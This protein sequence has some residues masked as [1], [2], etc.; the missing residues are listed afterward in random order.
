M[1]LRHEQILPTIVVVVDEVRAPAREDKSRSANTRP[2]GYIAEGAVAVV[3]KKRVTLIGEVSDDEVRK[4]VVVVIAEVGAHSGE[5][6]AVL[7]IA[8]SGQGSN[9]CECAVSVVV[10]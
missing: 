7:V 9:F 5:G 4:S 2:V 10:V 6:L 1:G 8:H 3:A